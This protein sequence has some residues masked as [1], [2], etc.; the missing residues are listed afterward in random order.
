MN[1]KNYVV[2]IMTQKTLM[3]PPASSGIRDKGTGG[4]I[5]GSSVEKMR[6]RIKCAL[7]RQ[8]FD[9]FPKACTVLL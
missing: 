8:K 2:P 7:Y 4:K 9:C 6:L 3:C 5:S 1:F